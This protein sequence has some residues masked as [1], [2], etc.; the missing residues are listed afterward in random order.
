MDLDFVDDVKKFLKVIMLR[1][2]K[3]S[4]TIGLELPRKTEVLMYLPLADLQKRVYLE[5]LTGVGGNMMMA[6]NDNID[7]M[8]AT[9]P[10][11]PGVDRDSARYIEQVPL[12][13]SSSRSI[14]H[15]LMELRKV[16]VIHVTFIA[17]LN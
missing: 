10:L 16:S 3:D 1:R 2:V 6:V 5:V 9:P 11:S 17:Y 14:S 12:N 4:T 7:C 8:P 13:E 15:I